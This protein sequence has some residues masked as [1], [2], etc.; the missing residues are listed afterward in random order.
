MLVT[1]EPELTHRCSRV[2]HIAD[3][4]IAG[5]EA[6]PAVRIAAQARS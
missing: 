5:D 3:G 1:H 2:I 4:R 6:V